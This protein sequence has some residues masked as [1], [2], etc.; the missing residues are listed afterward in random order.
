MTIQDRDLKITYIFYDGEEG[1]SE[2]DEY[3]EIKNTGELANLKGYMLLDESGK[4]YTFKDF[5][6]NT[7]QSVKIF[8]GCGDDTG[9]SL[10]WCFTSS[11]IWNNSGDAATLKDMSG[12][13]IDSYNYKK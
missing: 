5:N 3:V 2:P 10:Y 13:V 6:L 4:T 11:A 8:T 1:R 7:N 12:G 9:S